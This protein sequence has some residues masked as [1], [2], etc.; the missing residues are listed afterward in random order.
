VAEHDAGLGHELRSTIRT[1]TYCAYR[2]DP[3][4]PL[5]W[6]VERG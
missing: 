5:R 6:R 3:R 1:G 4:R 2:P